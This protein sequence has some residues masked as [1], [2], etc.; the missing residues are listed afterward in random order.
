M[1]D[2]VDNTN[3]LLLE[4]LQVPDSK[5]W[6]NGGRSVTADFGG[7]SLQRFAV[8][9]GLGA[10]FKALQQD[11]R[12]TRMTS[13]KMLYDYTSLVEASLIRALVIES[14]MP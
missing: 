7:R 2:S 8:L 14:G 4:A 10:E 5:I 11:E 3:R 13:H 1:L 9:L 6:F 12:K